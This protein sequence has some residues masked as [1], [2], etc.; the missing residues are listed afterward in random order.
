[1][2]QTG[3]VTIAEAAEQLDLTSAAVRK[4]V[5]RGKLPAY[6][7]EDGTWRVVLNQPG[8]PRTTQVDNG[9]TG[10]DKTWTTAETTGVM[11]PDLLLT[12][13]QCVRM[14][15]CASSGQA[16]STSC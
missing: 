14:R 8:Q 6:K 5:Q 10:D 16:L 2:E 9:R 13:L 7:A 4:R 12:H 3:G 1:M 15:T 11:L